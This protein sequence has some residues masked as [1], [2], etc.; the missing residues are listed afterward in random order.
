MVLN[1]VY[2]GHSLDPNEMATNVDPLSII[3]RSPVASLRRGDL[4]TQLLVVSICI[5]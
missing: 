2:S 5:Q 1:L 4:V 3:S